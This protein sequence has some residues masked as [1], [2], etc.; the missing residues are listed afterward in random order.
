MRT[1]RPWLATLVVAIAF[2]CVAFVCV[3]TLA[4]AQQAQS[5]AQPEQEKGQAPPAASDISTPVFKAETRLV[6]VDTVVTDKK[7]NYITGLDRQGLQG[8]GR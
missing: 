2:I 7:G 4:Q 1:R 8:L 5:Q 3:T 6:L